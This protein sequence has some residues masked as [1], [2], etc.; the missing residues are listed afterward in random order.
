MRTRVLL[1]RFGQ[2]RIGLIQRIIDHTRAARVRTWLG[3][4]FGKEA[5]KLLVALPKE[6]EFGCH[7]KQERQVCLVLLTEV[8]RFADN[9]ILMLPDEAGLLFLAQAAAVLSVLVDLLGR[10]TATLLAPFVALAFDAVFDGA[11]PVQE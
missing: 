2:K 11:Y 8:V 3:H 7:L 9:E 5:V 1:E 6:L 4:A 10:P